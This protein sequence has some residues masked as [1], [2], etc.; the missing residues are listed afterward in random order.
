MSSRP[1]ST[2]T[3]KAWTPFKTG[4]KV[5]EGCSGE[6]SVT[7]MDMTSE[8]AFGTFSKPRE[9]ISARKLG[10]AQGFPGGTGPC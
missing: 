6:V 4:M 7:N 9:L 8:A 1:L 10:T 2:E 5:L 3:G